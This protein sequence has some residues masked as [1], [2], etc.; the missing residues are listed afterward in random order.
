MRV[1]LDSN[2]LV[3]AALEPVSAKGA[4]AAE[5]IRRA[6]GR[7]VLAAQTLL[8]FVAVVRRRAPHLTGQAIAQVEAWSAVFE[9]APTTNLIAAKALTMVR[10][11]QFQVWDA[12]IWSTSRDAGATLFLSEDLQDGLVLDDM[13]VVNPFALSEAG[14]QALLGA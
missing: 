13:R 9:V 5:A 4:R 12:V 2:V 11:H 8:E 3:Y 1:A 14:I 10:V 6:S 7:G